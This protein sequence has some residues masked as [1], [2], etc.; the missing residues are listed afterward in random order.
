[1]QDRFSY[2]GVS[3]P[4]RKDELILFTPVFPDKNLS[5]M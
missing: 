5:I 2:T 1:M 4:L 3:L